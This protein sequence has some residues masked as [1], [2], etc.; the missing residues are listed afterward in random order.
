LTGFSEGNFQLVLLGCVFSILNA[1]LLF[2][3]GF[4][5]GG[6]IKDDDDDPQKYG[7]ILDEYH[8]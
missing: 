2:C 8:V 6:K 3:L 5:I 4:Y 7:K 1:W